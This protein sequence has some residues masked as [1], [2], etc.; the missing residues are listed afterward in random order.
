MRLLEK[1]RSYSGLGIFKNF[2]SWA[3]VVFVGLLSAA[4]YVGLTEIENLLSS[5][6]GLS[7]KFMNMLVVGGA[8]SGGHA[9]VA[10][11]RLVPRRRPNP[12]PPGQA[13]SL[14]DVGSSNA[15]LSFF[16]N[17]IYDHITER[18]HAQ[19]ESLALGFDWKIIRDA[20]CRLLEDEMTVGRLASEEG[21]RVV[22]K[23][24]SLAVSSEYEVQL[25][26]KYLALSWTIGKCS[27][28]QLKSRLARTKPSVAS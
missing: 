17:G 20:S 21:T 3:F 14:A 6:R 11:G 19:A 9:L 28:L 25:N 27:Y 8:G 22:D 4:S 15:I 13:S 10:L 23:I 26:N 24:H 5:L 2:Y 12:V 16:Y 1:F 18:M 7:P